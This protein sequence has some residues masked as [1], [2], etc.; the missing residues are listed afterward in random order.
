MTDAGPNVGE[1][2]PDFTLFTSDRTP[3]TLSS[4]RGSQNVLLA[5]FPFAFTGVCTDEFCELGQEI[6]QFQATGTKVM[7]VSCD[8][9]PSLAEFKAKHQIP[10][11]LLSDYKKEVS[12]MYGT[13]NEK[14]GY[15]ERAYFV[16]D[17]D[18]VLRWRHVENGIDER[19]DNA[20]LLK[21]LET[22]V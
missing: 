21:Q 19:R 9:G 11:E 5:F 20:E 18:G 15:S 8:A 3:I 1:E 17:Q 7:G 2:A 6:D 16:I 13:L 10:I 14:F 4:F 12:N 22:L